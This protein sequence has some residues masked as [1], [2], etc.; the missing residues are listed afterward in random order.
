MQA[1]VQLLAVAWLYYG[2]Y[3]TCF[4]GVHDMVICDYSI[5][6]VV[7]TLLIIFILL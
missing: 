1:F 6:F 3:L 2:I 7:S 5:I 4:F